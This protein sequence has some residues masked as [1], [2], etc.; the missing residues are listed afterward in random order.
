M[1]AHRSTF[2]QVFT[3][4]KQQRSPERY[5]APMGLG[6]ILDDGVETIVMG[7]GDRYLIKLTKLAFHFKNSTVERLAEMVE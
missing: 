7:A 3:I 6:I 1:E 2:L 4:S 5:A